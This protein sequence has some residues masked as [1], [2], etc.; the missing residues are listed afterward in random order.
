M[1]ELIAQLNAAVEDREQR[2]WRVVAGAADALTAL[3]A[4]L[5]EVEKAL[6]PFVRYI[7]KLSDE[8]PDDHLILQ[9][10]S[11]FITAADFRRA[12]AALQHKDQQG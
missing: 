10:E 9:H 12:R 6:E 7:G 11:G 5:S 4:R 8:C 3:L 2:D 1:T